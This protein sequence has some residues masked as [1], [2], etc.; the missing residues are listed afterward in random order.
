MSLFG[1]SGNV[2]VLMPVMSLVVML[3]LV[4][5]SAVMLVGM[6][7]AVPAAVAAVVVAKI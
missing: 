7:A 6:P 5:V 2:A 4:P 1:K 3:T